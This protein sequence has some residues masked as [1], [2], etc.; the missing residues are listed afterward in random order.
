MSPITNSSIGCSSPGF[1]DRREEDMLRPSHNK[2]KL[3]VPMLDL[4]KISN[5]PDGELYFL[6]EVDTPGQ[7]QMEFEGSLPSGQH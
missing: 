4:A 2:N 7:L 5:D 3:L 6:D 1:S